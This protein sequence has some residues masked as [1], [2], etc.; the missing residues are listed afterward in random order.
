MDTVSIVAAYQF[1]ELDD[2]A[3]LRDRL[4]RSAQQAALKGTVLLAP[5][6]INFNL[7]GAPLALQRWL[8][9]LATDARFRRLE[10]KR[11]SAAALPFKRLLV[12]VKREII[13][14]N[15]SGVRPQAGRAP[16]VDGRNHS[17]I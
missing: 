7:A 9:E 12:K 13:R 6:G 2:C 15:E 14:M 3:A 10:I 17:S 16:A 1:V 4:F 11:H 8:D 5:E